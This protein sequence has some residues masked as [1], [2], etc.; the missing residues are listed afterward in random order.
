MELLLSHFTKVFLC[1]EVS[2]TWLH[3]VK[4]ICLILFMMSLDL[5]FLWRVLHVHQ[6][7]GRG[8]CLYNLFLWTCSYF[9]SCS[10]FSHFDR[11]FLICFN[12][13][14]FDLFSLLHFRK[15][16]LRNVHSFILLWSNWGNHVSRWAKLSRIKGCSWMRMNFKWVL[17]KKLLD[18]SHDVN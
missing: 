1:D 3:V 9:I 11:S 12:S 10:S 8:F 5:S 13:C 6:S 16:I 2:L 15:H 4:N 17:R 14:W 7:F 18:L